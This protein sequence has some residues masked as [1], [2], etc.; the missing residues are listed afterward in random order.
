VARWEK[1]QAGMQGSWGWSVG[2]AGE[3]TGLAALA[4]LLLGSASQLAAGSYSP[5]LYFRF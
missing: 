5:F 4:A 2:V 1:W 3:L